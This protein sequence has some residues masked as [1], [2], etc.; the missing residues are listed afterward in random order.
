MAA[1]A[2]SS[3]GSRSASWRGSCTPFSRQSS[4]IL[5]AATAASRALAM[6]S[7]CW[8]IFLDSRSKTVRAL[9]GER[10]EGPALE[11]EPVGCGALAADALERPPLVAAVDLVQER[12][13]VVE[14]AL[15]DRPVALA[16]RLAE[17]VD[18]GDL[19][20]LVGVLLKPGVVLPA[21]AAFHEPAVLL[22]LQVERPARS[23]VGGLRFDVSCHVSL[24]SLFLVRRG[25]GGRCPRRGD[26]KVAGLSPVPCLG[27][28]LFRPRLAL[29]KPIG[30][31]RMPR[32]RRPR[33]ATLWDSGLSHERLRRSP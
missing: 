12:E 7:E 1:C 13:V 24:D 11:V 22:A 6:F 3:I 21:V 29:Y 4:D 10:A 18:A 20:E 17:A 5:C 25:P 14:E 32:G 8:M 16:E 19:G 33:T 27:V 9:L 31:A 2:L 23:L 28:W 15:A 26:G 30:A